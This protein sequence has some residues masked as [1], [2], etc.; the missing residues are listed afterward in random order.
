VE[1]VWR[2]PIGDLEYNDSIR[3]R[4]SIASTLAYRLCKRA[5]AFLEGYQSLPVDEVRE[6]TAA[7]ENDEATHQRG[8]YRGCMSCM[9]NKRP[10]LTRE[11]YVGTGPRYM[12]AG[13]VAK[14]L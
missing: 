10:L 8:K 13:D 9:K 1:A 5:F 2:V 14:I 4:G 12:E 7:W 6:A 3:I 11:G